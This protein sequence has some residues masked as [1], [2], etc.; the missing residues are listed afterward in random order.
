M[1]IAGHVSRQMLS[2]YSHIRME[3][4][5]KALAEVDRQRASDKV[6]REKGR[7]TAQAK[8]NGVPVANAAQTLPVQ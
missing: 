7:A 3:A 4:K 8:R 2:R 6:Q 1:E 5:R